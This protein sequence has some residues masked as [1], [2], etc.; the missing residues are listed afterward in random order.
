MDFLLILLAIGGLVV[1]GV[2]LVLASRA[3]RMQRESD[4]RVETLSAL[5]TGSV[6]FAGD[7]VDE[8]VPAPPITRAID[9][10]LS[11]STPT[12]FDEFSDEAGA[13]RRDATAEEATPVDASAPFERPANAYP[14]VMTVPTSGR[15]LVGSFE[16]AQHGRLT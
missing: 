8:F 9:E 1:A 10:F 12:A 11:L 14:F 15:P 7:E 13:W 6:L 16:R 2:M 4:A 5:A 3:S